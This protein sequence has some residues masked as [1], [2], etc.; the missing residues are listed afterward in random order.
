MAL[1]MNGQYTT[2]WRVFVR[3]FG[4]S[5]TPTRCVM[6]MFDHYSPVLSWN[7]PS[8]FLIIRGVHQQPF[9]NLEVFSEI[10]QCPQVTGLFQ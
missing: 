2:C 8:G 6:G 7:D 10:V 1:A 5:V 3:G 4:T 9:F